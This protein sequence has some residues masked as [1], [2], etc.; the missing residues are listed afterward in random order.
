[1]RELPYS[2]GKD[3]ILDFF[4]DFVLSEDSIQFTLNREGRPTGEAFVG[5]ASAEDSKVAMAKNRMTLGSRYIELFT[6]SLNELNEGNFKGMINELTM[7]TNGGDTKAGDDND[8]CVAIVIDEDGDGDKVDDGKDDSGRK[9]PEGGNLVDIWQEEVSVMGVALA[10]AGDELGLAAK[11][12]RSHCYADDHSNGVDA[13]TSGCST[14][15]GHR[16]QIPEILTCPP[17][18][19]KRRAL[20]NCSIRRTPIAFFAPPDIEHFFLFALRHIP[21]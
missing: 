17:A 12:W 21:A 14:P 19:K 7:G 20:P 16:F 3:D 10:M 5:F 1:M 8:V 4:K 13:P 2:A 9:R 6:S 15:R 18:P 11:G